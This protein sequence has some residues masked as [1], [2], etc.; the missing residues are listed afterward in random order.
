MAQNYVTQTYACSLARGTEGAAKEVVPSMACAS[1]RERVS[2]GDASWPRNAFATAA[3]SMDADLTATASV[4]LFD[5]LHI[6]TYA[7][8]RFNSSP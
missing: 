3:T 2:Q 1:S 4:A 7:T 6:L 8:S 5:L